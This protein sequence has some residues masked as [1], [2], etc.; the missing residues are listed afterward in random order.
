MQPLT[1][2]RLQYAS[3]PPDYSFKMQAVILG[4]VLG[5]GMPLVSNIV[6]IQV[7]AVL[8]VSLLHSGNELMAGV[9]RSVHFQGH[10][11]IAWTSITKRAPKSMCAW[12][13][14]RI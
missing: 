8:A 13:V 6:P 10:C 11:A 3:T 12:F 7:C 1:L 9:L 14:W 5:I 4:L 2:V